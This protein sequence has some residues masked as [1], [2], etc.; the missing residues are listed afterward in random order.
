MTVPTPARPRFSHGRL[1]R[2]PVAAQPL[3][4]RR[5]PLRS[6]ALR[7]AEEAL[8]AGL[9]AGDALRRCDAWHAHSYFR[10]CSRAA[11]RH[12]RSTQCYERG[13]VTI[14]LAAST[15]GANRSLRDL[16]LAQV[17]LESA[18]PPCPHRSCS[19]VNRPVIPTALAVP[20]GGG[21]GVP[22]RQLPD[23]STAFERVLV[24]APRS[25]NR[26]VYLALAGTAS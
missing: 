21:F 5:S 8:N 7:V 15:R 18:G 26:A 14:W 19:D 22:R 20:A 24:Y 12:A 11:R 2:R 10:A 17:N 16:P 23:G 1:G 4:N 13:A 25:Y 9:P 3:S 6:G